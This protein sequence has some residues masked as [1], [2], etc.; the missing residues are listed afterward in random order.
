MVKLITITPESFNPTLLTVFIILYCF[1]FESIEVSADQIK[2]VILKYGM[3]YWL[4][5]NYYKLG[6]EKLSSFGA[7]I[8]EAQCR[9][10]ELNGLNMYGIFIPGRLPS[11]KM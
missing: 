9:Q 4:S 2:T 3:V 10:P 5:V 6:S 11:L 7:R 8:S 1:R